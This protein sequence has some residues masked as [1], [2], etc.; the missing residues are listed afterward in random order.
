MHPKLKIIIFLS[1]VLSIGVLL[2]S[3]SSFFKGPVLDTV[4]RHIVILPIIVI[5]LGLSRGIFLISNKEIRKEKNRWIRIKIFI[6]P[7]LIVL[8]TL[9]LVLST[10]YFH[11]SPDVEFVL[12]TLI[13]LCVLISGIMAVILLVRW[14]KNKNKTPSN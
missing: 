9:V 3:Q 8:L 2:L 10:L 6:N 14:I 1:I 7:F 12:L 5:I 11:F 4:G 13:P